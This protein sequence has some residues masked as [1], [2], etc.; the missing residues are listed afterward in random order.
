ML[1]VTVL[2]FYVQQ[3]IQATQRTNGQANDINE[4]E[5]FVFQQKPERGFEIIFEHKTSF[6]FRI[7]NFMFPAFK[8]LLI[9]C[10]ACADVYRH[11]SLIHF[12]LYSAVNKTLKSATQ[13]KLNIYSIVWFIKI[14]CT[15]FTFSTFFIPF[16]N[17][18]QGLQ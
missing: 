10:C 13:R 1:I 4:A 15:F 12:V 9:A 8:S 14:I 5:T 6:R 11:H 3:D 2:I 18:L 7:L 17:S 16:S